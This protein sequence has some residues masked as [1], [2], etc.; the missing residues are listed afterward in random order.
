MNR[1]AEGSAE[2]EEILKVKK[3][4]EKKFPA[5]T[6]PPP[7]QGRTARVGGVCDYSLDGNREPL[8]VSR[9]IDLPM[10]R[11]ADFQVARQDDFF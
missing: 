8:D 3:V 7:A 6:Q 4:L 5:A 1:F 9:M 2:R 11:A 10:V